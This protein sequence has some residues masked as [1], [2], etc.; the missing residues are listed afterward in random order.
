LASTSPA[1]TLVG[2]ERLADAGCLIDVDAIAVADDLRSHGS[3]AGVTAPSEPQLI[4]LARSSDVDAVRSIV[5]AA[6]EVYVPRIG[7]EPAPMFADY[8]TL[9][10]KSFVWIAESSRAD[11]S[12]NEIV[13][14]LVVIPGDSE[15]LLENIAVAPARQ[16]R[17]IGRALFQF[18][19]DRAR[20]IG[21][22][23]VALY[24]N[25][26]MVENI[27][28]YRRLGYEELERRS[29]HGFARVYFRKLVAP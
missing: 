28:P 10:G 29:E 17:G 7:R 8:Q 27:Q 24:T 11:G 1:D 16:G 26:R 9:I 15:L 12:S 3:R 21:L 5:R 23:A 25:E 18:A 13:G 19:E 22:S 4:R 20:Q 2:V 14:I 6:Y